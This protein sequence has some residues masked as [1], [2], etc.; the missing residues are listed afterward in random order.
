[1]FSCLEPGMHMR[2]SAGV[3]RKKLQG[4]SAHVHGDNKANLSPSSCA[5]NNRTLWARHLR[6]GRKTV[7]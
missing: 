6:L 7:R 1:M 5:G 2:K 4:S 3:P